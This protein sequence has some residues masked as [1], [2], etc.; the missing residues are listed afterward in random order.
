ML[1][2]AFWRLSE[3][4]LVADSSNEVESEVAVN[5]MLRAPWPFLSRD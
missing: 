4:M 2:P 3:G 1:Q 5:S